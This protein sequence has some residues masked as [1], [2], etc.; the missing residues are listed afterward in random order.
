MKNEETVNEIV[1]DEEIVNFLHKKA[2]L[3]GS[4]ISPFLVHISCKSFIEENKNLIE[5]TLG[6]RSFAYYGTLDIDK[7]TQHQLLYA[8]QLTLEIT[9]LYDK[10]RARFDRPSNTGSET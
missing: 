5:N 2:A 7:I 6:S 3:K 8:F 1:S 9:A 4:D 10:L